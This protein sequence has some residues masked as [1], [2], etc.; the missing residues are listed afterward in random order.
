MIQYTIYLLK[1][2]ILFNNINSFEII[3][4]QNLEDMSPSS[5]LKAWLSSAKTLH[6]RVFSKIGEKFL[7]IQLQFCAQTS[8]Q[9]FIVHG[10]FRDSTCVT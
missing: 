2:T 7:T 10:S 9:L 8:I 3:K 4:I 6:V 5:T 1:N